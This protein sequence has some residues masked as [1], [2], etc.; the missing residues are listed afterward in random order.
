MCLR[1]G[2]TDRDM[3]LDDKSSYK[4]VIPHTE[5]VSKGWYASATSS[6]TCTCAV[7]AQPSRRWG[8]AHMWP[9]I[10]FRLEISLTAQFSQRIFMCVLVTCIVMA[11]YLTRGNVRKEGLILADGVRGCSPSCTEAMA[12]GMNA[13]QCVPLSLPSEMEREKCWN[14][15]AFFLPLFYSIQ[16]SNPWGGV[17]HIPHKVF[18]LVKPLQMPS[19]TC[20]DVY[21]QS[22]CWWRTTN[23][24]CAGCVNLK[25][26]FCTS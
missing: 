13:R 10:Y 15:A 12:V 11:K 18:H 6:V 19:K 25:M 2:E 24:W 21:V 5:T 3:Y 16:A 26:T 8:W 17:T 23:I 9:F 7:A 22:Q 20:P 4:S 14:S 1:E